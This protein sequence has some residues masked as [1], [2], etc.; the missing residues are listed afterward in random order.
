MKTKELTTTAITK[1]TL[2]FIVCVFSTGFGLVIVRLSR[3]HGLLKCPKI[4]WEL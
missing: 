3:V 2:R 1:R 4:K